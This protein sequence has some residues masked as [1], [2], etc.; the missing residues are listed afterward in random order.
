MN[1]RFTATTTRQA[2]RATNPGDS[3][4]GGD[5]AVSSNTPKAAMRN[6]SFAICSAILNPPLWLKIAG[7]L[8]RCAM[9]MSAVLLAVLWSNMIPLISLAIVEIV[10]MKKP[11]PIMIISHPGA[12]DNHPDSI[13]KNHA[14]DEEKSSTTENTEGSGR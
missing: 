3:S 10:F 5:Q 11:I 4:A 7:E 8:L 12:T 1:Q 9:W 14:M 13:S 6:N 2:T